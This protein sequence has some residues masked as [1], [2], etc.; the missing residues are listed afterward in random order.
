MSCL[1]TSPGGP[2]VMD[3]ARNGECYQEAD[4][5][6][7]HHEGENPFLVERSWASRTDPALEI[8]FA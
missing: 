2:I 5:G 1:R 8:G 3:V 7:T 4:I 6:Q